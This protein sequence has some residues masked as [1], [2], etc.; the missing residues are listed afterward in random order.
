[1]AR[2]LW[3][4]DE[5]FSWLTR[6]GQWLE[7]ALMRLF[8]WFM[9]LLSPETA[10][11]FGARVFGWLGPRSAKH[12]HVVANLRMACPDLDEREIQLLARG[13]WRN[14]G[15]VIAEYPH[16][17]KLVGRDGE[18]QFEVV[19][20]NEDAAFRNRERPCI[21]VAAHLGNLYFS[22]AALRQLGIPV[23]LVY[24]PLANP[25][26]DAQIQD[27]LSVL[28][29]G[30]ITKQN[31]LRPMLKALKQGRSVGLHVDVRVDDGELFPL[32]GEDATTTTGPAFLAVK[33]GLDIV[34]VRTERLPGARFRVTLFPALERPPEDYSDA[35]AIRFLT[36]QMNTVIGRLIREHPDQWMCTKRRWPK[37]R[38]RDKG[39]YDA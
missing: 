25:Y 9:S 38:M 4:G 10:S 34:P 16:L 5:R 31:A 27:Y 14:I 13:V 1:M 20:E 19:C 29:C 30:F 18:P 8:W 7:A 37:L 33:T 17:G 2:L 28:D 11:S 39:A 6:S 23:D 36:E 32:L 21:F 12:R 24:S 3:K 22:A 26:L 15:S 35:D